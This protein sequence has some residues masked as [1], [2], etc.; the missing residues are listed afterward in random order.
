[1]GSCEVGK[2]RLFAD[3]SSLSRLAAILSQT[4]EYYVHITSRRACLALWEAPLGFD[5]PFSTH[6]LRISSDSLA[7]NFEGSTPESHHLRL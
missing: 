4:R 7:L 3:V 1:M 6:V 2:R 5:E